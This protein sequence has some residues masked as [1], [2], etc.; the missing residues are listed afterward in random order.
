MISRTRTFEDGEVIK[1]L[2]TVDPLDRNKTALTHKITA[3]ACAYLSSVG[4]KPVETEIP[5]GGFILDV[6]SFAYPT[7]TEL[8][9]SKLLKTLYPELSGNHNAQY[10][11]F[12]QDYGPL[13]TFA[14]EVKTS[15]SDFKKDLGRKYSQDFSYSTVGAHLCYLAVPKLLQEEANKVL[16]WGKIICSD[17][18]EHILKATPPSWILAMHPKDIIDFIAQVA[19]RRDHRTKHRAMRDFLKTYRAKG[20]V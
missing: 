9:N 11:R 2:P 3:L 16:R 20:G 15:L 18:G 5:F 17:D 13:L 1:K 8:K 12:F 10:N 19:I 4:C 6:G 14:A 7:M